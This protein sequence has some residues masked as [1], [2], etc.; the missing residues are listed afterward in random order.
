LQLKVKNETVLQNLEN[1]F[2][3]VT[4]DLQQHVQAIKDQLTNILIKEWN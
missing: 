4:T 2:T 3:Q 1:E